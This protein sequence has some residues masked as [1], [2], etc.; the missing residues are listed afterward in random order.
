M[1]ER[2][3]LP[4]TLQELAELVTRLRRRG[5]SVDPILVPPAHGIETG[6]T[7]R[8]EESASLQRPGY[9]TWPSA[10]RNGEQTP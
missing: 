5:G 8:G 2:S 7:E 3:I 6:I 10:L 4:F 9:P 1:R